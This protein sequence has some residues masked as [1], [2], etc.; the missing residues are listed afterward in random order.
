MSSLEQVCQRQG[1]NA[2]ALRGCS[3]LVVHHE[4]VIPGSAYVAVPG[5]RFDGHAFIPEAVARGA[6]VVFH[7]PARFRPDDGAV[8]WIAVQDAR[9]VEPVLA[10]PFHDHPSRGLRLTGIT[11]T[12]GKTTSSVLAAAVERALGHRVAVVNTLGVFDGA[13]TRPFANA[14]PSPATLQRFLREC[15]ERGHDSVVLECSSW[16][17]HVGRTRDCHFDRACLTALT[18]DH[19]DVHPTMEAYARAK[20]TLVAQLARSDKQDVALGIAHDFPRPEPIPDRVAALSFGLD[21]SGADLQAATVETTPGGSVFQLLLRGRPVCRVRTNLLGMHNVLNIVGV[22]ATYPDLVEA[23]ASG[24][25]TVLRDPVFEDIH[26]PGRLERIPHPG[27][28]HAYVDYAHTPHA[29]ETVLRV[30]SQLHRSPVCVVFGCGGARDHGKRPVMGAIAARYARDVFLTS[31]NPRDEDPE[32]IVQDI[33]RGIDRSSHVV[34]E[35]DR[36]LAIRGALRT[37]QRGDVLLV[38]GKGHET[39]QVIGNRTIAFDDRTVLREEIA[40]TA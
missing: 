5:A 18:R 9:S 10:A 27:G 29:L 32:L 13:A 12:N 36:R 25:R 4:D 22:L 7:E 23:Q 21:G 38:A 3:R 2:K 1:W 39:E 6:R 37:V 34:V 30:L 40:R 16:A 8:T 24:A 15:L 17:L 28:V 31:D 19:L 11:G 20:W 26:V 14:L 35:P 33:A